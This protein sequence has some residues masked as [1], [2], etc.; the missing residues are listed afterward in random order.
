MKKLVLEKANVLAVLDT[1][2][3]TPK[4][5]ESVVQIEAAGLG[6][7]EYLA[8]ANPGSRSLPNA[9]A[10]GIVGSTSDNRRIAVYPVAGCE[11]CEYCRNGTAQ[12]CDQ[13]RMIGVHS[14]GGFSQ[15]LA[16][17]QNALVE[18]P[19]SMSWEQASFIE[20]FAN[21]INAVELAGVSKN[22]VIAVIGLGGLG[23][24]VVAACQQ[25]GCTNV[26]TLEPSSVRSK[27]AQSFNGVSVEYLDDDAFDVVFDTVG[28]QKS[29]CAA[30]NASKKNGTCVLLGFAE[31]QMEFE[32][33]SFIRKQKRLIGSFAYS[34]AQF[35]RA[36]PLAATTHS[37]WVNNL[38]F[39]DVQTQLEKF[40]SGNYDVVRAVLRPNQQ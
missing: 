14:D 1:S 24:G 21:S 27:A 32:A 36:V 11:R 37:E 8:L 23:L 26:S 17:P 40:L 16:V 30:L 25:I 12:L 28:T 29:R 5:N 2:S 9:M 19:E 31:A 18:I 15:Q 6:G 7:S 34:M 10:H 22:S 33:V 20:P 39:G 13:W 3:P 38:S 4:S 35:Q